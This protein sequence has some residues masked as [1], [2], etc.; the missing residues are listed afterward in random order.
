MGVNCGVYGLVTVVSCTVGCLVVGA[1]PR[2][3]EAA[4]L[5]WM[6]SGLTFDDGTTATGRFTFNADTHRSN[7]IRITVDNPD[8]TSAAFP[9]YPF[10]RAYGNS[11]VLLGDPTR[12]VLA[13]TSG[14]FLLIPG[15]LFLPGILWRAA[16]QRWRHASRIRSLRSCREPELCRCDSNLRQYHQHRPHRTGPPSVVGLLLSGVWAT[17]QRWHLT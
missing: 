5:T 11:D 6:L 13:E 10:P 4:S 17:G 3:A 2:P 12:L 14:P 15:R 8:P 16:D 7:Q 9:T 1:S